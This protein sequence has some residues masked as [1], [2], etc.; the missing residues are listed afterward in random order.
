MLHRENV[1]HCT[2]SLDLSQAGPASLRSGIDTSRLPINIF[3]AAVDA[4]QRKLGRIVNV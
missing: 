1:T 3:E 4:N 2:T